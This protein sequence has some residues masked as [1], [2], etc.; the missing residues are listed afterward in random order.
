MRI[1]H[2]EFQ[3]HVFYDI[4]EDD[5]IR[6]TFCL[7]SGEDISARVDNRQ[8]LNQQMLA[9]SMEVFFGREAGGRSNE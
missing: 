1:Q 8:H 7:G 3:N 9:G 6:D 4:H 5:E 2:S